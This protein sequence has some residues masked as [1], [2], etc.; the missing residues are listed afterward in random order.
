[1]Q[2]LTLVTRGM[3]LGQLSRS[4]IRSLF[5]REVWVG[6]INGLLWALIV[7]LISWLWFADYRIGLL[8][9]VAMIINLLTA[10]IFGVMIPLLLKRLGIDPALAGGVIL[11]TITDVVG[12]VAFLGLASNFLLSA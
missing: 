7:G 8:I 1:T 2:T 9:A 10:S 4:N 11:T 3:A 5:S 12:F 6:L